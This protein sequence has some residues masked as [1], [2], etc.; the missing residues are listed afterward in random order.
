MGGLEPIGENCRWQFEFSM[1]GRLARFS[2]RKM[3]AQAHEI[4][5]P[6]TPTSL[7]RDSSFR[8]NIGSCFYSQLSHVF[9]LD[10][11]SYP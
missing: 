5:S 9:T 11:T 1:L 7:N 6:L 2:E 4:S 3:F 10:P 8:K